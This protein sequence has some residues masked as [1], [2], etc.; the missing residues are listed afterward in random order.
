MQ[1]QST[2]S[3]ATGVDPGALAQARTNLTIADAIATAAAGT[4]DAHVPGVLTEGAR[5]ATQAAELLASAGELEAA[6]FASTGAR[7]LEY[8]D[9]VLADHQ[10]SNTYSSQHLRD[11]AERVD[12]ALDRA[13]DAI[14]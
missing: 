13:L 8:F 2:A 7:E 10:W 4:L 12:T 1:V 11:V 14:S 3:R 6:T 9:H 5:F